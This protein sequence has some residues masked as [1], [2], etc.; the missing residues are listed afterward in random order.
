MKQNEIIEELN[1]LKGEIDRLQKKLNKPQDEIIYV[2]QGILKDHPKEIINGKH[3]LF[4]DEDGWNAMADRTSLKSTEKKYKLVPCERKDLEAGD[5]A[6]S[7][8][9][10]A[11]DINHEKEDVYNYC[12]VIENGFV[13][14]DEMGVTVYTFLEHHVWYKVIKA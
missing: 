5:V 8:F 3:T 13:F 11:G 6:F 7:Y 2:P 1:R 14:W 9:P 10:E 12:I 4:Y